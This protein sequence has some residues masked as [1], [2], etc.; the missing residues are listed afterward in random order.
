[1]K[2]KIKCEFSVIKAEIQGKLEP[3]T[4]DQKLKNSQYY[5]LKMHLENFLRSK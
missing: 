5:A 1:L 4:I 3:L 2:A